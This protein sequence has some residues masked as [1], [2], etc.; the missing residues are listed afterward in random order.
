MGR[1]GEAGKR[2]LSGIGFCIENF[3]PKAVRRYLI[4]R[5]HSESRLQLACS[6]PVFAVFECCGSFGG[7]RV[8]R[9][10]PKDLVEEE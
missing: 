6:D 1:G 4:Q 9:L 7:D 5:I 10:R 2:A 3:L 8:F